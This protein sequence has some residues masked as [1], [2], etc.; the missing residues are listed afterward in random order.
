MWKGRIRVCEGEFMYR[1]I[2]I[3]NILVR[4][5]V[6]GNFNVSRFFMVE[7]IDD[8]FGKDEILVYKV[9]RYFVWIRLI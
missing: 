9:M 1:I 3:F 2:E 6:I 4:E 7:G 5:K 8:M